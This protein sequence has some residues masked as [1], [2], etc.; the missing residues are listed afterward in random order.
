[1]PEPAASPSV[2]SRPGRAALLPGAPG[3]VRLERRRACPGC[4]PGSESS[5]WQDDPS[6]QLP[7]SS[8]PWRPDA[9]GSR[10]RHRGMDPGSRASRQVHSS[11]AVLPPTPRSRRKWLDSSTRRVPG[12]HRTRNRSGRMLTQS[13][14]EARLERRPGDRTARPPVACAS[15]GRLRGLAGSRRPRPAAPRLDPLSR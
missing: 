14:P 8:E 4:R 10:T 13:G 1:M 5:R 7:Y 2:R 12:R 11:R 15:R 9:R 3:L 6:L